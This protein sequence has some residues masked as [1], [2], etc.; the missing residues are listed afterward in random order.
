MLVLSR[1]KWPLLFFLI[2]K[3]E[4][5]QE[6]K[7]EKVFSP[8]GFIFPW[9]FSQ[10]QCQTVQLEKW[11]IPATYCF[12]MENAHRP[13]TGRASSSS[14]GWRQKQQWLRPVIGV[15]EIVQLSFKSFKP[16][17]P[18]TVIVFQWKKP[19]THCVFQWKIPESMFFN[20]KCWKLLSFWMENPWTRGRSYIIMLIAE[21]LILHV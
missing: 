20:G 12:W 1:R 9:N 13:N 14:K 11:K 16:V 18:E 15:L 5:R 7:G 17:I 10:L 3:L 8:L 19:E 21:I 6:F 2:I 4:R